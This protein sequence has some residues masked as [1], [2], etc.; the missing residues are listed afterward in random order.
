MR[1]HCFKMSSVLNNASG[2]IPR[3]QIETIFNERQDR[4]ELFVDSKLKTKY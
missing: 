4:V 1:I 3:V 2:Q